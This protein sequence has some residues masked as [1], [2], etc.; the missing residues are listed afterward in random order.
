MHRPR[1]LIADDHVRFLAFVSDYLKDDFDII[2]TVRDGVE[3]L[4][5]AISLQPDAVVSDL[6]MPRM[7]GLE[8]A[9]E[10]RR[11]N[12]RARIIILTLHRDDELAKIAYENGV[13][14]YVLKDR[15]YIDLVP[16]VHRVLKG[17]RF[18]SPTLRTP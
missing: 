6:S 11:V 4:A 18:V 13:M 1:L 14:G 16:A 9:A 2:A 17:K 12:N 7:N 3:A 15:I 8:L 10:L 5:A